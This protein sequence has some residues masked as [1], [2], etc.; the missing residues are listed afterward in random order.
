M[1]SIDKEAFY[2]C[3]SLTSII[4]PD[5]VTSIGEM[6]FY[7]CDS[8]ASVTI[9]DSVTSIGQQ[10]LHTRYSRT[11]YCEVESKPD[12]WD[13]SWT[14]HASGCEVVWGAEMPE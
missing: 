2:E 6:A 14:T 1:T 10:A 9:P 3:D 8:L 4:I 5:S 12:G 7:D 11:T 13:I